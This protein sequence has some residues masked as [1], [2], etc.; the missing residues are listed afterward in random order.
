MQPT[1]DVKLGHRIR[2]AASG[3]FPYLVEGHGVGARVSSPLAERAEA[4][5]RY[6]DISRVDV[7]VDVEVGYIAVQSLAREVGH[8][9]GGEQV[10][11]AV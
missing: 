2:I 4:A 8:V 9:A 10:R 1:N 7:P 11:G 6:A 5:A 3:R